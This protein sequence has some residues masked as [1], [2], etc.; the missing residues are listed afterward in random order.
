MKNYFLMRW[1][2]YYVIGT[3]HC[4]KTWFFINNFFSKWDQLCTFLWNVTKYDKICT[5]I[6]KPLMQNFFLCAVLVLLTVKHC[7]KKYNRWISKDLSHKIFT[8]LLLFLSVP[9]HISSYFGSFTFIP[10]NSI[11]LGNSWINSVYTNH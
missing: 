9:L 10:Q 5:L 4:T 1:K 3:L 11:G 7:S 6:E 2:D 8:L